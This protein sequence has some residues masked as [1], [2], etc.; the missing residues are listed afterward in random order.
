MFDVKKTTQKPRENRGGGETKQ[1]RESG[2]WPTNNYLA[3]LEQRFLSG[4]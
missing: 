3:T 2:L 4:L 1:N